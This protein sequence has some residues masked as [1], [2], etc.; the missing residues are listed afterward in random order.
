[1]ICISEILKVNYIVKFILEL[2]MQCMADYSSIFYFRLKVRR[3]LWTHG[4][5]GE[6][7]G[8]GALV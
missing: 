5:I 1:M 2:R 4:E 6:T 3:D 8:R 7:V